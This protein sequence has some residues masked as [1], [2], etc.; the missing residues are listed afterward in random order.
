MFTMYTLF[1]F[2][3]VASVIV[4]LG[5]VITLSILNFRISRIRQPEVLQAL[6][7]T[8]DFYSRAVVGPAAILTLIAGMIT[9]VQMGVSFNT[10]WIIW[11]FIGIFLSLILDATFS[12]MTTNKLSQLITTANYQQMS[13]VQNRLATLN[14]ID[15]LILLS[16]VAAM[17]FKPML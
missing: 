5:G 2:L 1:K 8:S 14:L 13:S 11:G 10:L 16:V 4:W 6:S 7:R 12:R 3:H 17:V 9:A 15:V